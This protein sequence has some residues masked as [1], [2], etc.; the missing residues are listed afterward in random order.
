MSGKAIDLTGKRYGSLLV[1]NRADADRFRYARWNCVCDCGNKAVVRGAS[2]TSG[3]TRT[4]GCLTNL[5]LRWQKFD[6]GTYNSWKAMIARCKNEKTHNYANYGGRGIKVC[7]RWSSFDNFLEDMGKRPEGYSL[8]R[9]D[10]NGNYEPSN[11]R[12]ATMKEQQNNR[13]NNR[14]K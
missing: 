3:N 14:K 4:C 7:E 5:V 8:D 6:R 11:C 12:W 13:R 2:L 9:I 10:S 1:I